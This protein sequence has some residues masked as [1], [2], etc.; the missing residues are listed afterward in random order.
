MS[1][2]L[3]QLVRK[4]KNKQNKSD[5]Q[6]NKNKLKAVSQFFSDLNFG[7]CMESKVFHLLFIYVSSFCKKNISQITL[8]NSAF[9]GFWS[10]QNNFTYYFFLNI[11][12]CSR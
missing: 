4:E 11:A 7:L 5:K 1:N 9:N 3:S 10:E 6:A 12:K 2:C 8:E